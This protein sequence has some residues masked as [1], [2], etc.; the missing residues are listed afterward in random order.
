MKLKKKEDQIVDASILFGSGNKVLMRGRGWEGH[1]KKRAGGWQ[2]GGDRILYGGD[3]NDIQ[4]QLFEQR[5]VA[6]GDVELGVTISKSQMPGKQDAPRTNQV[7][8]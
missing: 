3:R 4:F 1:G 7:W 8:D 5:C 6:A 2:K